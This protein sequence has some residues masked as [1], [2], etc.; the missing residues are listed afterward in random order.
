MPRSAAFAEAQHWAEL[1]A[2]RIHRG[3]SR[4]ARRRVLLEDLLQEARLALWAASARWDAERGPLWPFACQ[5]VRGAVLDAV[6]AACPAI[7]LPLDD[8]PEL[9]AAE[10]DPVLALDA[11]RALQERSPAKVA[12][13]LGLG[14]P[15]GY[16][17][18]LQ[19]AEVRGISPRAVRQKLA[20]GAIRGVRHGA[21][22]RVP[23]WAA[24]G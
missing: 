3:L 17:T 20:A 7:E 23:A 5:R 24:A 22:W 19:V 4:G 11:R 9:A 1:C 12:A 21:V 15:A 2:E 16:L 10:R 14:G 8:A 18:V 6:R 13:E